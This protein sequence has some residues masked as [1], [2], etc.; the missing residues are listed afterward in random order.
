MIEE[1]RHTDLRQEDDRIPA[2][3]VLL[4]FALVGLIG[5]L[6]VVW[7]WYGLERREQALRPTG[8]FPEQELGPRRSVSEDLENIFG[9]VGPG[10]VLNQEKQK[11]LQSFEW[12]DQ[13]RRIVA[14][15]ID[16]AIDLMLQG[17]SP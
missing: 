13:R 16:D 1:G 14:I 11:K 12:V 17:S 9:D 4:V 8:I 7:A 5:V 2:S 6:L 3:I 10:Q 15:P